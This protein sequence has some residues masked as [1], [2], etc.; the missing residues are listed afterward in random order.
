MVGF[1]RAGYPEG[2][3][4]TDFVPLLA[5]L[6]RQLSDDEVRQVAAQLIADGQLPVS[7]TDIEVAITKAI[8]TMPSQHDVQRVS[9]RLRAGGWTVTE[10]L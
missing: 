5:L 8:D 3:P 1:L 9:D 6:Q 2:V 4:S 7:V 10:H